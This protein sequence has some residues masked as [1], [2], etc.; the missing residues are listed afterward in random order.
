MKKG[1]TGHDPWGEA[2]KNGAVSEARDEDHPIATQTDGNPGPL[3]VSLDFAES[4]LRAKYTDE[5]AFEKVWTD[6][7]EEGITVNGWAARYW[8]VP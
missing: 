7:L 2:V 5:K 4:R 8:L 6:L 1:F 3:Y